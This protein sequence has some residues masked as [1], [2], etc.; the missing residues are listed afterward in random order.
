MFTCLPLWLNRCEQSYGIFFEI[1]VLHNALYIRNWVSKSRSWKRWSQ[2]ID[3]LLKK[4]SNAQIWS[5]QIGKREI[6]RVTSKKGFGKLSSQ[7][8]ECAKRI[9]TT[10]FNNNKKSRSQI[11]ILPKLIKAN[12][13]WRQHVQV[14]QYNHISSIWI[15][16]WDIDRWLS[17]ADINKT[18]GTCI[19]TWIDLF[20]EFH[21]YS[22]QNQ[23]KVKITKVT[24]SCCR[25]PWFPSVEPV[26]SN[27]IQLDWTSQMTL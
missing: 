13:C 16:W 17:F 19:A 7:K 27:L 21:R 23:I 25:L 22:S 3:Q 20:I 8:V 10:V 5:S 15:I 26:R 18:V 1:S 9:Q 6:I 12:F 4:C 24:R 14:N 2:M 11:T